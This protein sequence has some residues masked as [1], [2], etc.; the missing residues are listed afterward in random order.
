MFVVGK[1]NVELIKQVKIRVYTL[2]ST[3]S[4]LLD[5][6][7]QTYISRKLKL[8]FNSRTNVWRLR[9][10]LHR[11]TVFILAIQCI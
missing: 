3:Q 5:A 7:K 2:Y 6:H 11:F 9:G 4:D 8:T 10:H 1:L